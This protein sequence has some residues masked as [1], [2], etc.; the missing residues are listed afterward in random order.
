MKYVKADMLDLRSWAPSMMVFKGSED[1]EF[2]DGHHRTVENAVSA[3]LMRRIKG[4]STI[5]RNHLLPLLCWMN[6]SP[7]LSLPDQVNR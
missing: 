6:P 4:S 5:P 7:H 3:S 2:T 1:V